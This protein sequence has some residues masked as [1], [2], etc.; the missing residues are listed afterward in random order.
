MLRFVVIL[1]MLLVF[2]TCKKNPVGPQVTP[3]VQLSTEYV[4]C[5]EVWLKIGFADSP[6]GGDY[7]ITRGGTTVLT[8]TFSG[9]TAVVC[10]TTGQANNYY[11]YTAYKLVNGQVKEISPPLQATTLNSTSH[12][13]SWQTFVIGDLGYASNILR[14]VAIVNDTLVY[15][16]GE[17]YLKDSAGHVDPN[18]YNLAK[19]DGHTWQP[20][21]VYFQTV[22][23]QFNLTPYPAQAIFAQSASDVWIEGAG[24]ITRWNGISQSP[25]VCVESPISFDIHRIWGSDSNSVFA[26]GYGGSIAHYSQGIWHM[27]QSGT[28]MSLQDVYGSPDGS[29]TYASGYSIQTG[30]SVVLKYEGTSWQTI[31]STRPSDPLWNLHLRDTLCGGVTSVWTETGKDLWSAANGVYRSLFSNG[32]RID[33]LSWWPNYVIGF[34]W[35]L[36]GDGQNDL[37]LVGD[38][39]TLVHWN[40]S[41]WMDFSSQFA[42]LGGSLRS[43]AV[44][45]HLVVAVGYTDNTGGLQTKAVAIIG[46][47]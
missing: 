42:S 11:S 47:R 30:E 14:D 12:N 26:V 4:S 41:T 32:G 9:A 16:V 21:R 45:N 33:R 13:F 2:L 38:Y 28:T 23:G 34:P 40:G 27:M 20:L 22:C 39:S 31:Y 8:G 43:V 15:A 24:E 3:N 18:A 35:M 44:S 1:S 37:I 10:D 36:R 5:T 17:I 46:K 25:P 29:V 19:W 7:R 6:S